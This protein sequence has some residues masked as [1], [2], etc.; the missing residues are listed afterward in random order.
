MNDESS[1]DCIRSNMPM[2]PLGLRF[3][4]NI[5][6]LSSGTAFAIERN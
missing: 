6:A 3:Y 1:D 5:P 4:F 2:K